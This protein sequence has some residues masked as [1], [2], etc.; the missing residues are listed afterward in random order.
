[1]TNLRAS[2]DVSYEDVLAKMPDVLEE[3]GF[4]IIT[5]IDVTGT[6]KE[7]LGVSFR[8]YVILGACNPGL[9]HRALSAD[10]DVGV[11]LPCNIAIYEDDAGKT[12]V[13]IV[14][15]IETLAHDDRAGLREIAAEAR[16]KLQHVLFKL[17]AA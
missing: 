1:M 7:K 16:T 9:A 2:L 4:G 17:T 5:R 14:D 15:P 10:L 3:H 8:K 6:L 12:V 11:L 13:K